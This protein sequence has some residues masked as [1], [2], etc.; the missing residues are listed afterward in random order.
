MF[1]CLSVCLFAC[2]FAKKLK[3]NTIYQPEIFTQKINTNMCFTH[4]YRA[5]HITTE[6]LP[7][8]VHFEAVSGRKED[9]GGGVG[10]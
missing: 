4:E 8:N 3:T 6:N 1:V 7:W 10:E 2:W 5:M 9:S